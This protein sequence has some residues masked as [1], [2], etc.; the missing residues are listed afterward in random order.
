MQTREGCLDWHTLQY[1]KKEN[2]NDYFYRKSTLGPFTF[3][4]FVNLG[5][6]HTEAMEVPGPIMVALNCIFNC[7]SNCTWY[8][9]NTIT[10]IGCIGDDLSFESLMCPYNSKVSTSIPNHHQHIAKNV[11]QCSSLDSYMLLCT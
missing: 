1:K 7:K 4:K 5:W 6:S 3:C 8:N 2:N 11:F 9:A 10:I